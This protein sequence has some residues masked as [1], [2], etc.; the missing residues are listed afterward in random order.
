MK[1]ILILVIAGSLGTIH[2]NMKKR[3]EIELKSRLSWVKH[4][5][6]HLEYLEESWRAEE[7]YSNFNEKLPFSTGEDHI[8]TE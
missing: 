5:W 1:V 6:D 3:L 2:K 8:H 4:C 7:T